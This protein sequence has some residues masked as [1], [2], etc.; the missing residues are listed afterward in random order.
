MATT[1][2]RWAPWW[3]ILLAVVALVP[4][5]ALVVFGV[6][7]VTYG[8]RGGYMSEL[9]AA[10]GP[11]LTATGLLLVAPGVLYLLLRRR[12]LFVVALV[13]AAAILLLT[14]T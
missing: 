14:L 9:S 6:Q 5:G 11:I 7:Q 4:P 1:D 13:V 10:I 12:F 3:A 8:M 2:R